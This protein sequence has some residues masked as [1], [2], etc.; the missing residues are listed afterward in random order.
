MFLSISQL[1]ESLENLK[2]LHPFYGMTFLACKTAKLPVGD[3]AEFA[4]KMGTKEREFFDKYYRPD[5]ESKYYYQVFRTSKKSRWLEPDYPTSGSQK[6][7]TTTFKDAF[8]HLI[9]SDSWTWRSNYVEILKYHLYHKGGGPIPAFHLAVWLYWKQEW[10]RDTTPEDMVQ[11][12]LG[13]FSITPDEKR[14][15]FDVSIPKNVDLATLFQDEKVSWKELRKAIGALPP[16]DAQ[17]E[18]GGTLAYLELQG[19]GPARQIFFE[20]ASRLNLITGDNGLGKTF[21]LECAWWA[22]TGQWAGLPAYRREDAKP[23][24]EPKITFQISGK[25]SGVDST[26][27]VYDWQTQ[28]WPARKEQ[29]TIPGLL[30]YARLDGSFAVWDPAK[31]YWSSSL[32]KADSQVPHVFSREDVWNGYDIG[33]GVK[34]TFINGLLRDWINWQNTPKKSPFNTFKKV[35]KRLS[36]PLQSDLGFLEPGEPRRLLD[37]AKEIPTLKHSYGEVPIVHAAAGVRRIITLAYLIVWAWEEHKIQSE[38]IRKKPES[39]MVI[40]I[41]EIE[42][43]LHPQWQ[44]RILPALLDVTEDLDPVLQVQFFIATHSPLVMASVEPMFNPKTDKLFHLNITRRDLIESQVEL[45]EIDF[46]RYGRVDQ[47]LISNIFELD[48]A[49]SLEAE[50]AIKAAKALQLQVKPNPLDIKTVSD[51]LV[52]YLAPNDEFWP[53]WKYFAEKYGVRFDPYPSTT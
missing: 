39:R 45:E 34:K 7:R 29:L 36:P 23:P 15:L 28:S 17:P 11:K 19:I 48:H 27:V 20:P 30:I 14:E 38:L 2:L 46:V 16:L 40:M 52:K 5:K 12:F 13:D 9:D 41:D 25:S 1:K 53:R 31:N 21:L 37:D 3:E 18:E 50:A 47:W 51:D 32:N 43:H 49:R 33:I 42:A 44:R 4:I 26:T 22:L 35:L 8:N 10:S 6:T 24:D